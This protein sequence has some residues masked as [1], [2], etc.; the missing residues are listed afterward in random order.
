MTTGQTLAAALEGWGG[1]AGFAAEAFGGDFAHFAAEGGS[2]HDGLLGDADEVADGPVEGEA[3]GVVPGHVAGD[4]G[5][6]EGHH[7]LLLGVDS[8]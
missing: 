7:L 5:H 3:G 4:G 6:H 8:G 2:V 1:C